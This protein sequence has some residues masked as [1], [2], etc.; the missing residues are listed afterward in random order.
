MVKAGTLE[1]GVEAAVQL[2]VDAVEELNGAP[3]TTMPAT[4]TNRVSSRRLTTTLA[5][6][7]SAIFTA[8]IRPS[9]R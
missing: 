6:P 3:P 1:N 8:L 7:T 4:A 9:H 2:A 5:A